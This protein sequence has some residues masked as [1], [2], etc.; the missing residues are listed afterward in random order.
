LVNQVVIHEGLEDVLHALE[1]DAL[2]RRLLLDLLED[3]DLLRL[4][5]HL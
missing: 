4:V 2:R 5:E 1:H 3:E